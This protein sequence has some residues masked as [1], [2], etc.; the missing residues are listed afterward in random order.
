M[1]T[2]LFRGQ[3]RRDYAE[4]SFVL[5]ALQADWHLTHA[6]LTGGLALVDPET[7]LEHRPRQSAA[8]RSD[9]APALARARGL[10]R[11]A[12]GV[13]EAVDQLL[14]TALRGWEIDARL[15]LCDRTERELA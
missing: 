10:Y 14:G 13:G 11:R 1:L 7:S 3:S 15:A 6:R 5:R 9:A 12:R 8:L 4:H 2:E